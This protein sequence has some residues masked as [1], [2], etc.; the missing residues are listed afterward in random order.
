MSKHVLK[1]VKFNLSV[2]VFKQGDVY[3]AYAPTLDISTY[4]SSKEEARKNF[5]ELVEV[6]LAEF[7]DA[8]ELAQVLESL[9][10]TKQ[11]ST[12][13]PPTQEQRTISV[14]AALVSA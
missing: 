5:D 3:V 9:G 14:P 13:Q 2:S 11:K 1:N 8:R 12:W 6:F 10:W 4:G 7:K